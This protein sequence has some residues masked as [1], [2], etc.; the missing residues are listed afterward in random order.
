ME[1]TIERLM[2]TQ[3]DEQAIADTIVSSKSDAEALKVLGL[4]MCEAK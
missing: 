3:D 1:V 2:D 4:K